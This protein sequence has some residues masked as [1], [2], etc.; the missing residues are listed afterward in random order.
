MPTMRPGDIVVL[1]N[2]GAHKI[3]DTLALITA[4]GAQTRYFSSYSPDLNPIETMWRKVEGAP[5]RRGGPFIRLPSP[6]HV[7]SPSGD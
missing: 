6:G 2:L 5:L 1:V 7:P 3:D 4:A